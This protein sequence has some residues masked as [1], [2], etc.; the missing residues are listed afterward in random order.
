[1]SRSGLSGT[2]ATAAAAAVVYPRMFV[3]LDFSGGM[4]RLWSGVGSVVTMSRTF[5][6]V[7]QFGGIG[8]VQE[9]DDVSA[10]GMSLSLSGVPS[11]LVTAALAEHY[12]GRPCTVWMGFM[13]AAGALLADPLELYQGLMSVMSIEDA[14]ETSR[15]TVDTESHMVLLR[16]ARIARWSHEEQQRVLA[17]DMGCEFV[18]T[19]WEKPL[20]WGVA[21]KR[22]AA[23]A[24][25]VART[26]VRPR[27]I[28]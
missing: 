21:S 22:S 25:D 11:S 20:V 13:D 6:G 8:A 16:R 26:V 15:I 2:N 5:S 12:R 9:R 17:G 4:V 14:G 19:L 18:A 10:E 27:G 7:G 1:M 28:L 24:K 23:D 3:E